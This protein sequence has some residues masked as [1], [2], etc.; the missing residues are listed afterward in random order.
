MELSAIVRNLD[1][2]LVL[3]NPVG[4]VSSPILYQIKNIRPLKI[5]IVRN[6]EVLKAAF[7]S[8]GKSSASPIL[9]QN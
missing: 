1:G 6:V 3:Q 9:D 2:R 4:K 5:P 7:G 8:R